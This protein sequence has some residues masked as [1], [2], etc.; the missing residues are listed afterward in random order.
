[1]SDAHFPEEWPE[2]PY[3]EWAA[4]KK[5]LQMYAQMLG[6]ARIALEPPQPEWL[7]TCLYLNARGLTTGPMPWGTSS[8]ELTLDVYDS[9]LS[10]V[11]SDGRARA[12]PLGVGRCVADVYA[13]FQAALAELGVVADIW[14]KPQEIGDTTPF[15]ENRHDCTLDAA[16]AQ[17]FHRVL[18]ACYGVFD[19]WRS[20]FFGRTGMQ[21]WW[22]A[23]DL[24]I[25]RFS[26][27]HAEAPEDRGYIMRYD[28]D[29]EFVNAGFWPGD[30]DNPAA[31][32]YAYIYP[33]P[34]GCEVAPVEP[35]HAGWV[36]QMGEWMMPYD[37]VRTSPNPRRAILDFL[38]SVYGVAT[39]IGGW[40]VLDYEY[41]PPAPSK[42][43]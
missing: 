28:L 43:E 29:A 2:L 15:P 25:L 10:V 41:T 19:E 24:G 42:R 39:T 18:T 34:P 17:R 27:R 23:F 26:G 38:N 22:G 20:T 5:T 36:E 9:T 40:D 13:D 7:A 4:T 3:A 32:F 37:A 6:K 1:M 31:A 33:Q 11:M 35:E 16:Q 30:D 8:V 14:T 12:V 21:F